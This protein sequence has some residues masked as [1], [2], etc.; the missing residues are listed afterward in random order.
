M[1]L[2]GGFMIKIFFDASLD[3]VKTKATWKLI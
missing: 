2:L 1:G 3:F